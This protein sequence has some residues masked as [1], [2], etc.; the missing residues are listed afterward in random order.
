MSEA[1]ILPTPQELSLVDFSTGSSTAL[2]S[3]MYRQLFQEQWA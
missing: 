2:A 3:V 1:L